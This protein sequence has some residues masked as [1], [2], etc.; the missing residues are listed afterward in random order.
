MSTFSAVR[1]IL[2]P[3]TENYCHS[4]VE[5][6]QTCENRLNSLFE[7]M[8]EL[9]EIES[10]YIIFWTA[11][12]VD[13]LNYIN[14]NRFASCDAIPIKKFFNVINHIGN[15]FQLSLWIHF[16][17][18]IRTV[19]VLHVLKLPFE[20]DFLQNGNKFQCLIFVHSVTSV[21]LGMSI[22]AKQH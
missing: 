4:F 19:R 1:A 21:Q 6:L 18:C 17:C 3:G 12:L 14:S 13:S 2:N 9:Q 15:L 20:F 10:F 8:F 11:E 16:E 5:T 7:V 22:T